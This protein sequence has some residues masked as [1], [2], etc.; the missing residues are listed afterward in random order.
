M[1]SE[2]LSR[3]ERGCRV[4]GC[5]DGST[6]VIGS[7]GQDVIRLCLRHAKAWSNSDLCR[8]FAA[9]GHT[10]SLRV[11]AK[12][13]TMKSEMENV[14]AAS[15]LPSRPKSGPQHLASAAG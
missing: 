6:V 1:E 13:I 2:V 11:L 12:W 5:H 3:I 7:D 15:A 8:D 4:S 9:N 14:R 10:D